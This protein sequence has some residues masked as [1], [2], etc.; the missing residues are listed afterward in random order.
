MAPKGIWGGAASVR[1]PIRPVGKVGSFGPIIPKAKA[2]AGNATIK[3]VAQVPTVGEDGPC[4]NEGRKF[5]L[6]CVVV[7]FAN[8]G[9]TYGET[10]LKR[11]QSGVPLFN[12]EGVRSCLKYLT[13]KLGYRVVG[14]VYE[15]FRAIDVNGHEVWQV[16]ADVVAMCEAVELAPRVSGEHQRSADDEVTI[17][18]AYERNC[19]ILDNDNYKDW[20]E[21]MLDVNVR[22][23]L[24]HCQDILQMR[25]YFSS[26]T[27]QFKTLDGNVD[28]AMLA[29]RIPRTQLQ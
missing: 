5:D 17:K 16:P 13:E 14:V 6:T 12:Y 20:K 4:D 19:R 22:Q 26:G 23:W 10:V 7:N 11:K 27:G 28:L 15:N 18:E 24:I 25:F 2:K 9:C 21:R 1:G 8:V 3:P 29:A